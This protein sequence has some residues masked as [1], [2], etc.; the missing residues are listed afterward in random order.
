M[1]VDSITEEIRAI[2][3]ALAAQYDNDLKRIFEAL[4]ESEKSSGREFI[5][6]P[7]RPVRTRGATKPIQ[8]PES[9]AGPDGS[10]EQSPPLR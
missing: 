7:P 4:R 2:R 5:S 1:I 3:H 10:A 9:P 6:L 8:T